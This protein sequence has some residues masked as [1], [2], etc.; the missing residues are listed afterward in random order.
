MDIR[1]LAGFFD[2]EGCIL[3]HYL[4]SSKFIRPEVEISQTRLP[5]LQEFKSRFGGSIIGPMHNYP[6]CKPY[7]RWIALSNKC[8][9]FLQVITKYLTIKKPQAKIILQYHKW[10][11]KNRHL[12]RLNKNGNGRVRTEKTMK[13]LEVWRSRIQKLSKRGV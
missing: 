10:K 7:W 11:I 1:Y 4:K 9:D 2:G 5:I 6:R 12:Y 3:F 8:V 13:K